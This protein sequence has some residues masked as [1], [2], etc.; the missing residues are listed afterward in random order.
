MS[1]LA[2]V[3]DEGDAVATTTALREA[4]RSLEADWL[5][6]CEVAARAYAGQ[7]W[8]A[9]GYAEWSDYVLAEVNKGA[10]RLP[11]EVRVH[12]VAKLSALGM[13]TRAIAP[14]VGVSHMQVSR[15]VTPAQ[16]AQVTGIDGKV[17][18]ATDSA[19]APRRGSIITSGRDLGRR[20]R[21]D[22]ERL[23]RLRKDDRYVRN[24]HELEA[25]L[26][27]HLEFLRDLLADSEED[28]S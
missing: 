14:V 16:P 1:R 19:K 11:R 13:S 23:E 20:L 17:Y 18:P 12:M 7:V 28:E 26:R 15:D 8:I 9:L 25:I 3:M 24:R 22:G 4:F 6:V 27:P 2:L 5:H 21:A 10:A